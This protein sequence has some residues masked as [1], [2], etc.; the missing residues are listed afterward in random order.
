MK[1][2]L[3]LSMKFSRVEVARGLGGVT[4][5]GTFPSLPFVQCYEAS[6][7]VFMLYLIQFVTYGKAYF[8]HFV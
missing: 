7:T 8:F 6:P 1:I 5:L 4:R 3:K 2:S